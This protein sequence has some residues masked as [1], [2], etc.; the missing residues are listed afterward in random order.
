MGGKGGQGLLD[1][2]LVPDVRQDFFKNRNLAPVV[3]RQMQAALSHESEQPRRFQGDRLAAGVGAGD[4]QGVEALPQ[5]Q[6]DGH[7]LLLV[8]QRMPSVAEHEPAVLHQFRL[9]A[10]HLIG[11]LAPGEDQV[12]RQQQ[13]VIL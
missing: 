10:V 13:V 9:H 12:Q 7:R 1:G 4:D 11:Q 2:L 5:F 8:Q 6:V 3:H